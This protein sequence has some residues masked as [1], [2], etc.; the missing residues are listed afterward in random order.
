MDQELHD[1]PIEWG[2]EDQAAS[3]INHMFI[4][5]DGKDYALRFYQLMPPGTLPGAQVKLVKARHVVTLA[6]SAET[7][8]SMIDAMQRVLNKV[9][10]RKME[11]GEDS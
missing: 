10:E 3:Y 5:T 11:L 9:Q 4:S 6:V 1:V 7:L 2:D 8:Q